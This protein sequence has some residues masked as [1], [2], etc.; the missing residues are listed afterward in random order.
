MSASLVAYLTSSYTDPMAHLFPGQDDSEIIQKV[1]H[2]HIF[3]VLP[4]LIVSVALFMVGLFVIYMAAAGISLIPE[5]SFWGLIPNS[6]IP[7]TAESAQPPTAGFT[8]PWLPI[9]FLLSA[10]GGFMLIASIYIWRQNRMIMTSENVVD[11]D[12]RGLFHRDI[13]TLRLNKVQDMTVV[14]KGPMQTFFRY[15]LITIQT[16]GEK[17]HFDFDYVPNP[18][19]VKK[20]LVD[21]YEQFVERPRQ[22][23]SSQKSV[24]TASNAPKQNS[25]PAG[26]DD[27]SFPIPPH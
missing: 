2:K 1:V 22:G 10:F 19:E 5:Q 27:D 17:E 9:G 21:L 24:E 14:V 13:A 18:Y 23:S 11:I 26:S 12:Q 3:S 6:N 20:Y 4:F 7:G 8:I 25:A 16:A 15:G